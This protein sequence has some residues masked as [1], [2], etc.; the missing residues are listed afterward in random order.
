MPRGEESTTVSV[1][2]TYEIKWANIR[3]IYCEFIQA[4]RIFLPLYPGGE[5]ACSEL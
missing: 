5:I 4:L 3:R 1:N 2:I